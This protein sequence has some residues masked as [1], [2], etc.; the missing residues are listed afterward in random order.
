MNWKDKWPERVTKSGQMKR[1]LSAEE[2]TEVWIYKSQ[3]K[4]NGKYV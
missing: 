1:T 4:H 2:K 3:Q